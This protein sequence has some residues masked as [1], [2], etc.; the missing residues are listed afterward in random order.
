VS[1]SCVS[2]SLTAPGW[3]RTVGAALYALYTYTLYILKSRYGSV[4]GGG[5][6]ALAPPGGARTVGA[7]S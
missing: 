7:G 2:M 5:R 6:V 4:Q 1:M 3:A